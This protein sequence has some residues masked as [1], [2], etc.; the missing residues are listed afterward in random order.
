MMRRGYWAGLLVAVLLL[1]GRLSC[2]ATATAAPPVFSPAPEASAL[3]SRETVV[4]LHGLRRTSL[5]MKLI[6]WRLRHCGYRVLN[7]NYPTRK[8]ISEIA[9]R[10]LP[11][12]LEKQLGA[13][14][15]PV[16]FVTHS[17]GGIVLRQYLA[18]HPMENLGRVVMLAPPNQGSELA[19]FYA[20]SSLLR[21]I[22][23]PNL[24]A[25]GTSPNDVPALLG[26]VQFELG[27]VAGDRRLFPI[28]TH[29]LKGPNDGKV[30]VERTRVEGM[31]DQ[32]IAHACH[33][34]MTFRKDVFNQVVMFL[35]HGEFAHGTAKGPGLPGAASA[36]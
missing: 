22:A 19:D 13:T 36:K 2:S 17:M 3:T 33:T 27:V 8:P 26:P 6:E 29:R 11:A 16:H 31:K 32:W 28:P 30:T 1:G 23:G 9:E 34:F 5:S 15:G 10:F 25:L 4:L 35:N 12:S 21:L 18:D 20:K 7:I 24:A 14:H